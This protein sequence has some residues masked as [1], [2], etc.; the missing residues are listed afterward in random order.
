[1]AANRPLIEEGDHYRDYFF[2]AV[3][4]TRME[5]INSVFRQYGEHKYAY[6]AETLLL[7]MREA[8]FSDVSETAS[9]KL[10]VCMSREEGPA[11]GQIERHRKR[12]SD[13][14]VR[15]SPQFQVQRWP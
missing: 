6:D 2:P 3:Y 8:G 12:I 15:S 11:H 1:L 5:F 13:L 4:K 10:T 7:A 14:G 9:V